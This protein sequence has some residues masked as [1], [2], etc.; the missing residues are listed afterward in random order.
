MSLHRRGDEFS[1]R[2]A[3]LELMNSRQHGSEEALAALALAELARPA[4]HV[5]IGGLGMGFTLRAALDALPATARVSVAELVPQVA[6]WNR[7]PLAH[8]AGR[9]LADGRVKLVVADVADLLA[10]ATRAYDA[11]LLDTDN[12]PEGT[13]HEGN[14]RLYSPA[15][16]RAAHGALTPGGVLA[17]WSAFQSPAFARR[18]VAAGFAVSE[19]NVRSRGKKGVRHVVW[20]ARRR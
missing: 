20:L 5:L 18:L 6:E 13:T 19:K 3:G 10:R 9:P 14:E 17:V 16:L 15:G 7:G 11:V 1:L 12:G 8:L 4:Q 2:V